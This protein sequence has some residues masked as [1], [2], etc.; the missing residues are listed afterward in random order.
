MIPAL[1]WFKRR[2]R[3]VL[4]AGALL[5]A[6]SALAVVLCVRWLAQQ[7][8]FIGESAPS[9]AADVYRIVRRMLVAQT[10]RTLLILILP[11]LAIHV[12][13]WLRFRRAADVL[14]VDLQAGDSAFEV[15]QYAGIRRQWVRRSVRSIAGPLPADYPRLCAAVRPVRLLRTADS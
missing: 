3:E 12:W 4:L 11:A 1:L 13:G 10:V 7:P 14:P 9:A 5:W 2:D 6:A 15:F 8:Y